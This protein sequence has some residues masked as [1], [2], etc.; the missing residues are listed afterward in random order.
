MESR[1][2]RPGVPVYSYSGPGSGREY[3]AWREE[4]CRGFCQ[5]DAEP[6]ATERIECMVEVARI[7]SLSFGA[8]RGTSGSFVRTRGLLSDGRDDFVLVTATAGEEDMAWAEDILG[9]VD[10]APTCTRD[11]SRR[12]ME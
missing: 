7:G 2:V 4:F 5:L 8:A 3:E 10:T 11:P 12:R 1:D 6:T 9:A